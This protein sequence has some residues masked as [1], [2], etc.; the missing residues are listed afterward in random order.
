MLRSLL[1]YLSK[2]DWMRHRVM[3]WKIARKVA[4]RFVAG[5][6]LQDA[7]DVVQRLNVRS[8]NATLDQLGE[9]THTTEEARKTTSEI[10]NILDVIEKSGV[11]SNLSIKLTQIGLVLDEAL[12]GEN[13]ERILSH[14]NQLNTF[15]RIDMEDS[16]CVDGTFRLYRKMRH[17]LGYDNVGMVLQSYLFRS[18]E[19]TQA[20][21]DDNTRI[22]MVKGAYN[23]PPEIA[24]P[25][26]R[27]VDLSFDRLVKLMLIAA[28]PESSPGIS[29]DGKWP[30]I[31][32]VG[33]HDQK[34]IDYAIETA[35]QLGVP[36]EKV[37]FQMLYGIRRDIQ[38]DLVLRGYPVRIYVPYGTEWY[39]YFMR[40][41]AE[42]PANLWF[43]VSSFFRR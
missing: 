16:D 42:R 23:E 5:E 6:R 41:L 22:R 21:L 31:T 28:Q 10:L 14:A 15:V 39:P 13:L 40:R 26:K 43:F 7:I 17:E 30:P 33:T 25:K 1:I 24:Y 27:D 32:A 37:E 11:Q 12:C 20:L 36:K 29:A 35:R 19:D 38:E 3:G 4:L 9:D 8:M 34:R 18:D 2:A